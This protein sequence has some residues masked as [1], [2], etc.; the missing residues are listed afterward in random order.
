MQGNCLRLGP[1]QGKCQEVLAFVFLLLNVASAAPLWPRPRP[2]PSWEQPSWNLL[3]MSESCLVM[4]DSLRPYGLY[5]PWNSPGQNTGVGSLSLLQGISPNQGLNPGFQHCRWILYHL[6]HQGS[7]RT[8]EWVAYS[9]STG[10]SWPRNRIG[11]SW[12]AGRFFT[13]W[14]IRETLSV[15]NYW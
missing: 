15:V 6:S 13:N 12:I 2:Q 11:V 1:A 7:P 9:F 5:S 8:L 3:W 10:S 14:A 4:S